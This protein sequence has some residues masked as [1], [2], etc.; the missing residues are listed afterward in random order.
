MYPWYLEGVMQIPFFFE[1][2]IYLMEG[3]SNQPKLY[4]C[5]R[6]KMYKIF[7][8]HPIH[9]FLNTETLERYYKIKKD[10]HNFNVLK[11]NRNTKDYG[12]LDFFK[13]LMKETSDGGY[14]FD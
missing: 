14:E 6:I 7:N 4:F 13:E 8:F 5:N 9:L 12:I 10:Y 2:D 3:F 11:K 1:D